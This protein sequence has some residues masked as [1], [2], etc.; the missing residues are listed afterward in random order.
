MHVQRMLEMSMVLQVY[1]LAEILRKI[2]GKIEV[3]LG[4]L[5]TIMILQNNDLVP[6]DFLCPTDKVLGMYRII[7]SLSVRGQNIVR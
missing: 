1:T 7:W 3:K 2:F 6:A 5:L 4:A